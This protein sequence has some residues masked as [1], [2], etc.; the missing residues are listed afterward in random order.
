MS[1]NERRREEIGRVNIGFPV[2]KFAHLSSDPEAF[3][4]AAKK[5]MNVFV[6]EMKA[7]SEDTALF[8]LTL[9]MGVALFHYHS[10][11]QHQPGTGH[12]DVPGIIHELSQQESQRRSENPHD[13]G[14]LNRLNLGPLDDLARR[15]EA[16]IP[17]QLLIRLNETVHALI[18]VMAEQQTIRMETDPDAPHGWESPQGSVQGEEPRPTIIPRHLLN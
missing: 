15:T 12:P 11:P 3:Y 2:E 7:D 1:E 16:C 10:H 8:G 17:S 13:L 4:E 18:E 14:S 9:A 6:E 5:A